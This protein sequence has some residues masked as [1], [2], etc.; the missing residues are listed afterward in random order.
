MAPRQEH[1]P[2][3]TPEDIAYQLSHPEENDGP[4]IIAISIMLMVV[5]T[6]V[7]ILRFVARK[8][9]KLPWKIDDYM[10]IPAL[11]SIFT[12]AVMKCLWLTGS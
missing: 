9:R 11:V 8:V 1:D 7:V 6:V 3:F 4:R 2:L 12:Q 5:C 10:T